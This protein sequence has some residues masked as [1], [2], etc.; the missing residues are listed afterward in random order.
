M[1]KIIKKILSVSLAFASVMAVADQD[2]IANS[3]GN[4]CKR[5]AG[6]VMDEVRSGVFPTSELSMRYK[7]S[8]V[9]ANSAIEEI[10]KVVQY[11]IDHKEMVD[12]YGVWLL[13]L[14]PS[15][16]RRKAARLR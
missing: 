4:S 13:C 6:D 5:L 11:K 16:T 15:E 9:Y 7:S 1:P 2:A 8:A 3:Y 10:F 12:E 14:S